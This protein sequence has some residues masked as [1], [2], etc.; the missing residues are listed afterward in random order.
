MPSVHPKRSKV[1]LAPDSLIFELILIETTVRPDAARLLH[2]A[3]AKNFLTNAC[4][5]TN[6][7]DR[8]SA[9][10]ATWRPTCPRC[11]HFLLCNTMT[12]RCSRSSSNMAIFQSHPR[13]GP[14]AAPAGLALME[15]EQGPMSLSGPMQRYCRCLPS[16]GVPRRSIPLGAAVS[17]L[18]RPLVHQNIV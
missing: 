9:R 4:M 13:L 2:M 16:C 3:I 6:H 18:Q 10:H 5:N 15:Q 7:S 11:V 1:F 14:C 17:A 12:H 8:G